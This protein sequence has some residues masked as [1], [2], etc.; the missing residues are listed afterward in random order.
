LVSFLLL[1]LVFAYIHI[2]QGSVPCGGIYN[3]RI[4]VNCLQSVP[5]KNFENWSIISEDI[6]KSKV[7]HF[8]WPMVYIL[9]YCVSSQG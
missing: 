4:I 9:A 1:S 6:D 7:P 3:N 8:L 2:S 5:E